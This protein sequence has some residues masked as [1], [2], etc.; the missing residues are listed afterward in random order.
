M[1]IYVDSVGS[2]G[3]QWRKLSQ[4]TALPPPLVQPTRWELPNTAQQLSLQSQLGQSVLL[5]LALF[6]E[7][8]VKK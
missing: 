5:L 1:Q 7:A 6:L 3:Y 8:S 4:S 2:V